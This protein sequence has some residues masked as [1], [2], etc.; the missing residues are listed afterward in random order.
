MVLCVLT[1]SHSKVYTY[2]KSDG[3]CKL[4]A[5]IAMFGLFRK[6][7]A[8]RQHELSSASVLVI[9]DNATDRIFVQKVL[10]RRDF[11]VFTAENGQAGLSLAYERKPDLIILDYVLPDMS[12]LDLCRIL[13]EDK[14]TQNIPIIFLTV[15][16]DGYAMIECF[17][18]GAEN[19]LSKPVNAK[20]L[21]NEVELTLR[22]QREESL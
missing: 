20:Q 7:N 16:E 11:C 17:E 6:I 19:F 22:D 5:K 13:K 21:L 9:E 15:I 2:N 8:K 14:M 1:P 3:L 10:G 12:G 18:A 4:E